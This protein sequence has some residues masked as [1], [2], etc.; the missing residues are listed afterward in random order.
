M[1]T[2]REYDLRGCHLVVGI[3][4]YDS[5]MPVEAAAALINTVRSCQEVGA[6][7]SLQ[8]N[9]GS[10]LIEKARAELVHHFLHHSK[11]THLLFID[12]DVIWEPEAAIALLAH[13][14][15]VDAVCAPYCTKENEPQF[16][17]RWMAGEDGN[18]IQN[19]EGLVRIAAAPLGFNCFS[20]QG[21]QD[22][23]DGCPSLDFEQETGPYA[24]ERMCSIFQ[25]R[26]FPS[27]KG[28]PRYVGEDIAFYR[29]WLDL[30]GEAWLDPSITLKHVGRK[31]Y[32]KNY[33]DFV[34]ERAE[35]GADKDG[36]I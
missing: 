20:R 28:V 36:D 30:V 23:V 12:S 26:I 7:F 32:S 8:V 4:A 18:P 25:T 24:G 5:S 33:F 13:C 6:S 15:E 14:T 27:S 1:D 2:S 10:A 29:R 31:V 3:P 9:C 11:G 17:Y 34:R 19:A 22:V 35:M 16:H 21:L